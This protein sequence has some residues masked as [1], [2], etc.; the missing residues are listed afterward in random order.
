MRYWGLT[1]HRYFPV[2]SQSTSSNAKRAWQ[3]SKVTTDNNNSSNPCL[4]AH[5]FRIKLRKNTINA[6]VKFLGLCNPLSSTDMNSGAV[7]LR[8]Y[9]R[10][11]GPDTSTATIIQPMLFWHIANIKA[12]FVALCIIHFVCFAWSFP[13]LRLFSVV[14]TLMVRDSDLFLAAHQKLSEWEIMS[15]PK[16]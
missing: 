15:E 11:L 9:F 4:H 13:P 1:L 8:F 10:L 16:P 3:F 5:H 12:S 14:V 7:D 6:V 2:Y